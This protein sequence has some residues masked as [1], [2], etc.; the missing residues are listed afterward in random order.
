MECDAIVKNRNVTPLIYNNLLFK[1]GGQE[2]FLKELSNLYNKFGIDSRLNIRDFLLAEMTF[3]FLATI[4]NTLNKDMELKK[5]S[6]RERNE[7]ETISEIVPK[8]EKKMNPKYQPCKKFWIDKQQFRTKIEMA[9]KKFSEDDGGVLSERWYH[10]NPT[11]NSVK[12]FYYRYQVDKNGL[13]ISRTW[14][15]VV[16]TL[17]D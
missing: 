9:W 1:E 3:N 7:P 15:T 17:E 5:D 4:N 11:N 12:V 6:E 10:L 13:P 14:E 16:L 2:Q 8:L